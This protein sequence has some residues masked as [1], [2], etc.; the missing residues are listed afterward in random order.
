MLFREK[1]RK[2]KTVILKK[3]QTDICTTGKELGS[4]KETRIP[5]TRSRKFETGRASLNASLTVEA[6]LVLPVFGKRSRKPEEYWPFFAE[7][8][9][10]K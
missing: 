4:P 5:L 2:S 1:S 9:L 7:V 8:A 3:M 6:A 10:A